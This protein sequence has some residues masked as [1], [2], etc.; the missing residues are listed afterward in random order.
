MNVVTSPS[1]PRSTEGQVQLHGFLL[2]E[3]LRYKL[4]SSLRNNVKPALNKSRLALDSVKP[5]ETCAWG[6]MAVRPLQA[7]KD[8]LTTEMHHFRE[9]KKEQQSLKNLGR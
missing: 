2:H 7:S 3:C 5:S 8:G 4:S 6:G 9:W 1:L